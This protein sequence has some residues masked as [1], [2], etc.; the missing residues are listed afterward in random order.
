MTKF[1]FALCMLVGA[2]MGGCLNNR[3]TGGVSDSP[4]HTGTA[5]QVLLSHQTSVSRS[6]LSI[7]GL[8]PSGEDGLLL[9]WAITNARSS[10]HTV[11]VPYLVVALRTSGELDASAL[12]LRRIDETGGSTGV[13]PG[14][15]YCAADNNAASFSAT[16][17]ALAPG[18]TGTYGIFG[19]HTGS[20]TTTLAAG[21]TW[22]EGDG[23]PRG[24][25]DPALDLNAPPQTAP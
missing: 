16:E 18:E 25:D 14:E 7:V 24:L 6:H 15:R 11:N 20:V 13:A 1:V 12:E 3:P 17:I 19:P 9:R 2:A 10:A 8:P 22:D 21:S 23:L 4:G 5:C